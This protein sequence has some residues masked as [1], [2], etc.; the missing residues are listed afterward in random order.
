MTSTCLAVTGCYQNRKFC[1]PINDPHL[2]DRLLDAVEPTIQKTPT[3]SGHMTLE[4]AKFHNVITY[5]ECNSTYRVIF[6]P[7]A[8]DQIVVLGVTSEYVVD[9]VDMKVRQKRLLN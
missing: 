2:I 5:L 6:T 9:K 4:I 1:E 3:R 8:D 7:R